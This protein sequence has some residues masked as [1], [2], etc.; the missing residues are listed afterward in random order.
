[1]GKVMTEAEINSFL[2]EKL[3]LHL[4]TVDG[5]GEPNIQPVWFYHDNTNQ[6]I[7]FTTY[8]ASKKIQNIRKKPNVYF[9]IDEDKM[10][11]RC[12]KGK[13]L[14]SILESISENLP[15]V[16]KICLKYNGSLDDP[17]S[18]MLINIAKNGESFAVEMKPRFYST[19]D[20]SG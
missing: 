6:K 17:S 11:Y 7:Y 2:Q 13:A 18:Q 10:P 4:A 12:V 16:E 5:D 20:F 9:S 8:K 19:W 3:N 15:I 14:V 1:M